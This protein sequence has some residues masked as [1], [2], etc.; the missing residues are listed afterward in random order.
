M[1]AVSNAR[2]A[3]TP[4]A[5]LN[6]PYDPDKVTRV[7]LEGQSVVSDTRS[8][9]TSYIEAVIHEEAVHDIKLAILHY[10]DVDAFK[11]RVE[12]K[13]NVKVIWSVTSDDVGLVLAL[14]EHNGDGP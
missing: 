9:L 6:V 10:Y 5:I 11:A 4:L 14:R 8:V 3:F 2:H 7:T 1:A 13:M 12:E